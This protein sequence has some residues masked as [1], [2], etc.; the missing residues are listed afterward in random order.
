MTP[1]LRRPGRTAWL[2]GLLLALVIAGVVSP[3]AS[4]LPDGLEWVAATTGFADAATGGLAGASPLADYQVAGVPDPQWSGALA[5]LA[6]TL[7]VLAISLPL[8]WLLR[9]RGH[10]PN[11]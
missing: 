10:R 2:L 5:G 4:A 6:G 3:Y 9:R 11:G 7:V 8:A 1:Q